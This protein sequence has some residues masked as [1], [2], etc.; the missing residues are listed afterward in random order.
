M[1]KYVGLQ[2]EKM[3]PRDAPIIASP[4]TLFFWYPVAKTLFDLRFKVFAREKPSHIL[5]KTIVKP[6]KKIMPPEIHFQKS[7]GISINNELALRRSVKST[8][9][10]P[11]DRTTT[12]SLLL[13]GVE[14]VIERPTIT[15][16][17]GK[18]HGASIVKTP[19]IN[20]I[21]SSNML[22]Y[23]S[24]KGRK[25]GATTPFFYQISIFINLHKCM[26]VGN[27]VFL[28]K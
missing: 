21:T 22:F 14:S 1:T 11:S 7:S 4:Q 13:F 16:R 2:A 10:I 15:G 17:R 24:Y 27:S 5:G 9:E 18:I 6:K 19:A 8:M 23:F 20:E 12:K 25:G 28:L 3:G 26:L